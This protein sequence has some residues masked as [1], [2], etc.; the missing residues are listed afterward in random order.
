MH[1]VLGVRLVV[2]RRRRAGA[3]NNQS[4]KGDRASSCHHGDGGEDIDGH[5]RHPE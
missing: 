4:C 3:H 1:M 5:V 2:S